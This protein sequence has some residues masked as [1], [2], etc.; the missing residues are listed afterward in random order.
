MEKFIRHNEDIATSITGEALDGEQM[1]LGDDVLIYFHLRGFEQGVLNRLRQFD[2][3]TL[4]D[5]IDAG[6]G[7]IFLGELD[8]VRQD[9]HDQ[10]DK[11]FTAIEAHRGIKN[12]EQTKAGD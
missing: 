3:Q 5:D 1:V 8:A 11:L 6:K 9:L 4:A 12:E 10:V 7:F 2:D